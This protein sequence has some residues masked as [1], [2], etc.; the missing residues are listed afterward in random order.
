MNSEQTAVSDGSLA[1]LSIGL[2]YLSRDEIRVY[3]DDVLSTLA[4]GLWSWVGSTGSTIAFTPLVANLVVVKI[5]RVTPTSAMYNEF[6]D[7]SP[8]TAEALD[9]NFDQLLHTV[10]EITEGGG[11]GGVDPGDLTA[12]NVAFTP[13]VGVAATNVQAAIEEV[14]TDIPQP[15][16]NF[17]LN[18]SPVGA[19]I[20]TAIGRYALEDHVHFGGDGGGGGEPG[21]PG[22]SNALVYAYKRAV[23]LPLDNPGDVTYNFV[24][25][26]ITLPSGNALANGWTKTIPTGTDPLYATAASASSSNTTDNIA[27]AEWATPVKIVENGANGNNGLNA[28]TVYIYQRN[29][30][31]TLPSVP[32]A[33]CTYTFTPPGLTGLNNGWTTSVPAAGG[34]KYL[35]VTT[36]TAVSSTATDTIGTSEWAAVQVM[37]QDGAQGSPGGNGTNGVDGRRGSLEVFQSG[38]TSWSDSAA[39]AAVVA[40]G[41]G[42][43]YDRDTVTLY[44]TGFAQKRFYSSGSWLTITAVIDGNLLVTGTVSAAKVNGGTLSGVQMLIGSG[45]HTPSGGVFEVTNT[46]VLWFD[47]AFGG[48]LSADN[49]NATS[50]A[51][52]TGFSSNNGAKAG[53]EGM[54]AAANSNSGACGVYGHSA[55]NGTSGFI[56]P[57]LAYDFYANGSGTNYGPFTGAHD[58]LIDSDST[59]ALGDILSDVE[60]VSRANVSNTIFRVRLADSVDDPRKIGVV[61]S[62]PKYMDWIPAAFVVGYGPEWVPIVADSYESA[63]ANYH[64]MAMNAVGEGQVNVCGRNGDIAAGDYITT[65]TMPGKGQKQSGNTVMAYTVAQAREGVTFSSPDEVKQIACIYK[66]G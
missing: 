31:G 27:A 29:N 53:V 2:T 7:G 33:T 55:Y 24:V 25:A 58:A 42:G 23:S 36:A 40:A 34:N 62:A 64:T 16:I 6:T 35:F 21:T 44:G 50:T 26:S 61:A 65:S 66:C 49:Y 5:K 39:T 45:G 46:G 59:V 15:A 41:Y 18:N 9:Q 60:C 1:T 38:Y 11:G 13:A 47:S 37:A 48:K 20:G 19:S 14:A 10:Q 12:E 17:P 30:T 22:Y 43:P 4:S 63:Q 54:V 8:F 51:A 3:F 57:N 56:A 52:V 32:S 28:A